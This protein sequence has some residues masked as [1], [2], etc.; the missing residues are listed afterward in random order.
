MN[1][2]IIDTLPLIT[3]NLEKKKAKDFR[4]FLLTFR[5]VRENRRR[6]SGLPQHF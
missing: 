2:R 1:K 3:F 4:I 5:I 6:R